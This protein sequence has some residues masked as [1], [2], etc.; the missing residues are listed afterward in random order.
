MPTRPF[1]LEPGQLTAADS[2]QP[3]PWNLETLKHPSDRIGIY[4]NTRLLNPAVETN[5]F[6]YEGKLKNESPKRDDTDVLAGFAGV[7]RVEDDGQWPGF[8]DLSDDELAQQLRAAG[9][10]IHNIVA[11][12]L[13]AF[14]TAR[15][16]TMKTACGSTCWF[17][18]SSKPRTK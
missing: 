12:G 7:T 14:S 1:R 4:A 16:K 10:N 8:I 18:G 9:G 6:W 13:E 5:L 11:I 15:P 17:V 3:C 2:R